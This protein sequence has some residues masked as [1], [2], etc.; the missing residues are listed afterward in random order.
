[1]IYV[2]FETSEAQLFTQNLLS[3]V[4]VIIC[5]HIVLHLWTL[6]HLTEQ[7]KY[8]QFYFT[9]WEGNWGKSGEPI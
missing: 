2:D 1:M 8:H 3:L 5:S 7:K 9:K 6:E 4:L